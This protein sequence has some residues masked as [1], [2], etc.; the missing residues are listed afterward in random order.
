MASSPVSVGDMLIYCKSFPQCL[1]PGPAS[2]FMR[3]STSRRIENEEIANQAFPYILDVRFRT[4][5]SALARR[6]FASQ[7]V[8]SLTRVA[9]CALSGKWAASESV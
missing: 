4:M 7:V 8:S 1:V 5:F 9:P 2:F 3:P 6:R